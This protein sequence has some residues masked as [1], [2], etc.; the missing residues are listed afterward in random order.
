MPLD[1]VLALVAK[2]DGWLKEAEHLAGTGHPE[3][4][5]ARA[6]S[7][8]EIFLTGVFIDPFLRE[9][10]A[11]DPRVAESVADAIARINGIRERV[12]RFLRDWWNI[13]V[14]P[15]VDWRDA[16]A[17]WDLRNSVMHKGETAS[18]EKGLD[19]ARACRA[20]IEFLLNQ[21]ALAHGPPAAD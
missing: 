5:I 21:R 3:M 7:A 15:S 1:E 10:P 6:V 13:D 17:V 4:A 18:V 20:V 9:G 16:Q 11:L 12:P 2:I 8:L 14:G 19:A